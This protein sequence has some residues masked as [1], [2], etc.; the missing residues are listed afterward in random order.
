MEFDSLEDCLLKYNEIGLWHKV[1]FKMLS[2]SR[3]ENGIP[4]GFSICCVKRGGVRNP[5]NQSAN[6]VT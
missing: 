1:Q 3:S 6:Q 5:S 4:H 2:N